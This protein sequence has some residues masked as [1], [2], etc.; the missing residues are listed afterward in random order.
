[1]T[2]YTLQ[3]EK[4]HKNIVQ[5]SEL[6]SALA[7]MTILWSEESVHNTIQI[8][9]TTLQN[10]MFKLY[11]KRCKVA[12]QDV[13]FEQEVDGEQIVGN[14]C[15]YRSKLQ[16]DG[17]KKWVTEQVIREGCGYPTTIKEKQIHDA[18]QQELET[19]MEEYLVK[20]MKT[21]D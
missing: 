10:S 8:I 21:T 14:I 4:S 1:M 17:S 9:G 3:I 7:E 18:K 19:K 6:N 16:Q 13:I 11:I 20:S 2:V 5:I 12:S 15:Q